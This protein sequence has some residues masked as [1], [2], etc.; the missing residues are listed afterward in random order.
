MTKTI[1]G[2]LVF[3]LVLFQSLLLVAVYFSFTDIFN[4]YLA[5]EQ[6]RKTAEFELMFNSAI[7][8]SLFSQNYV[9]IQ[10]FLNSIQ[11]QSPDISYIEVLDADKRIVASFGKYSRLERLTTASNTYFEKSINLSFAGEDLGSAKYAISYEYLDALKV[12]VLARLTFIVTITVLLS[13]FIIIVTTRFITRGLTRL[14]EESQKLAVGDKVA[15]L[16]IESSDE[17]GQLTVCFNKMTSAIE[18][19]SNELKDEQDRL[20]ALLNTM[21]YGI[22]FEDAEGEIKY[23]NH[24]FSQIWQL[25]FSTETTGKKAADLISESAIKI[26]H[27][28]KEEGSDHTLKEDCLL[29]DGRILTQ[30]HMPVTT[31]KNKSGHLWVYEDVTTQRSMQKE[32]SRLARNDPLTGLL[33]RHQFNIDLER[34]SGIADRHGHQLALLFFDLDDFKIINDSYGHTQGDIILAKVANLVSDLTRKDD[35]FYRLGGDEFALLSIVQSCEQA[36]DLAEKIILALSGQRHQFDSNVLRLTSSIGISFF[37]SLSSNTEDLIAHADIA[38]YRAK[39][40]GKNNYQIYDSSHGS[41]ANEIEKLT[42]NEKLTRAFEKDLFELHFQGIYDTN[43]GAVH[44]LEALIRLRDEEEPEK[45]IPPGMFIPIAEKS[46]LILKIDRF[47]ISTVIQMLA[48]S[49]DMPSVAINISGKSFDDRT[50][51]TFIADL[52]RKHSVDSKR[53]LIELTETEAVGD[54]ADASAFI[55][56]LQHL[57]C[58]VCLDD[59]GTGF[60][61]FSYL[62]HLKVDV[63]KID[64]TFIQNLDVSYENQLFVRSMVS[65]A[66]GLHKKTIAEFVENEAILL[67]L[68]ELG[69]DMAQGYY[70]GKP[71]KNHLS[72]QSKSLA[73]KAQKMLKVH[74]V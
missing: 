60:S 74:R 28:N 66:K 33:N 4:T 53:L 62:K 5:E 31:D 24:R 17:V 36:E 9:V 69:V 2:R 49:P 50:L 56:S 61:S 32:L 14:T 54:I 29:S 71:R 70:L 21:E 68:Q 1:T 44:H 26:V 51:P 13:I 59:F 20:S 10:E 7:S 8:P 57:G 58:Q 16:A 35:M 30:T 46:G 64:G 22:L 23:I 12:E 43:S 42:W 18:N 3:Y 25:P 11:L 6:R 55:T 63:L 73:N 47:V 38:M 45:L 34:L 37:P 41:V 27:K 67:M 52:L 19:R 65:V 72:I 39:S 48:D 15:Q 40:Q